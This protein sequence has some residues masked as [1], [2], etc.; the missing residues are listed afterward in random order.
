MINLLEVKSKYK[1]F[2]KHPGHLKENHN[3]PVRLEML[4]FNKDNVERI[5]NISLSKALK[6][7]T[8]D[9]NTWLIYHSI[10]PTDQLKI[11]EKEFKL[12][13]RVIKNIQNC[14][15]ARTEFSVND[16]FFFAVFN[17]P[18]KIN[19]SDFQL[20]PLC[21]ITSGKTLI[22]FQI[23]DDK[24]LK[25]IIDRVEKNEGLICSKDIYYLTFSHLYQAVD[26]YY[27]FI[28]Q[29]DDSLEEIEGE[30]IS[31]PT[32]DVLKKL[33]K[34]KHTAALMR[35]SIWP[36]REMIHSI[37]LDDSRF[38]DDTKNYLNLNSQ[39]L[40]IFDNTESVRER[41]SN[42]LEIYFSSV[43]N[44]MNKTSNQINKRMFDLAIIATIFIPLTFITG[45]YG[46]NFQNMELH[47]EYG[48]YGILVVMGIL[49]ILMIL[50][51]LREKII[52]LFPRI[53]KWL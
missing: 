31:S 14:S 30:I 5:K 1:L 43:S 7:R 24:S 11:I 33:Q 47:G 40:W 32:S 19:E 10:P 42:M 46:M 15:T 12:D 36:L 35:K 13:R 20:T 8:N 28:S 45:L 6:K 51:F 44:R 52:L 38:S 50:Y 34:L 18:F 3:D 49:A 21:L 37:Y 29:L 2:G 27:E 41:I 23:S 4:S 16:N 25:H 26:S 9:R 39:I 17:F 53:K 22:V 48:P